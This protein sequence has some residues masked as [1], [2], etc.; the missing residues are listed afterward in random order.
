[1]TTKS[2]VGGKNYWLPSSFFVIGILGLAAVI[3]F[4]KRMA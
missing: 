2:A 3:F 4:W 1:M